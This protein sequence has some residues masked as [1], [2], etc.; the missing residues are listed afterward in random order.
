MKKKYEINSDETLTY[1]PE[2]EGCPGCGEPLEYHHSISKKIVYTLTGTY[3]IINLGY[4]C[5]NESCV[6]YNTI[7]TSEEAAHMSLWYSRYGMD[8]FAFVG[9][10][11]FKNHKTR[12]EIANDLH[13]FKI[14]ISDCEVEK[15][16]EKYEHLLQM[17][18]HSKREQ[19]YQSC[20]EKFGGIVLSM[21][22]VQPGKGNET[23]YVLREVLSG[24]V[25]AAC[26]MKNGPLKN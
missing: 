19:T 18:S 6:A 26:S 13:E 25:I 9:E 16:Y 14:E 22:G 8:V 3:K 7:I 20:K 21:D 12:L 4:S 24:T 23:L 1:K 17:D 15:L 5:A 11:R 10:Q 2:I